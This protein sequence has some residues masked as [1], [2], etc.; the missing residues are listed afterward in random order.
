[1]AKKTIA[2]EINTM[3]CQI[4][5]SRHQ[6]VTFCHHFFGTVMDTFCGFFDTFFLLVVGLLSFLGIFGRIITLI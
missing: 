5:R 1:M 6:V 4:L 2:I 3:R